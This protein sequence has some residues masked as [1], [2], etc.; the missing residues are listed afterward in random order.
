MSGLINFINDIKR[1]INSDPFIARTLVITACI[2]LLLYLF[3]PRYEF[4][5]QNHRCDRI[6]GTVEWYSNQSYN[7]GWHE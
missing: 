4:L 7:K 2:W 5:D 6:K 1:W 3:L